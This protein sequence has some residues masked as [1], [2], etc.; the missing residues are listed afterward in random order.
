MSSIAFLREEF[1]RQRDLGR[2]AIAQASDSGINHTVGEHNSIGVSV[3]HLHGLLT[4]RFTDFLTSDNAEP[5]HR[6]DEEFV[7]SF[8]PHGEVERLYHKAWA[9]VD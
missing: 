7:V 9:M 5:W 3:E 6:S 2:K 4:A 1:A 8:Y